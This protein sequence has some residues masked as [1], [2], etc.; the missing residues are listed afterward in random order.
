MKYRRAKNLDDQLIQEIV[1]ILDGWI[2]PLSWDALIEKVDVRLRQRYTRQT[3]SKH[4]RI[5]QAFA[6]RKKSLAS[7]KS[8]EPKKVGDPALQA[9]LDRIARLEAERERLR[10]E[11]QNLLEQFM[12]WTYNASARGLGVDFLNQPL[13]MVEKGTTKEK[14]GKEKRARV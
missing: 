4:E 11:N 13:P 10:M 7:R 2:G 8:A 5:K 6:L 1:E 3:L 9:A 12:R 14:R